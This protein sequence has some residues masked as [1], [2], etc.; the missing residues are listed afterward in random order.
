MANL[1]DSAS[2]VLTPTAYDNGSMLSVKPNDGDGDFDF[3]RNSAATRVNAQGLVE[4]VQILSGDLVSNGDFS[5]EGVQEVSNGSFSQEGA[6]LITNGDFATDTGW[7]KGTGWSISSG[8]ANCNGTTTNLVSNI[9]ITPSIGKLGKL[10]FEITNYVSGQIALSLNGTG[11]SDTGTLTPENGFYE[12]D[13]FG[14]MQANSTFI[15]I[16]STAFIGSI[17]NVSVKEVL[18]D[19]SV[20]DYGAVSPSAV[21]TPNTEGVKLEK[22]VSAD[23]RSSFLVQPISYNS[24]SQY[25][26]TFKLKNG[27]LPSGGSIYVRALY[28]SSSHSI[29]NNLTLTNDWVEY[30]YYYTADSNSLDISFGN[31]D[32]Q[33][34]GVGQ[35]FYINDVSVKEVGQDW[36]FGTG[37]SIGEDKAVSDG[38]NLDAY[39]SQAAIVAGKT[40]KVT[41]DVNDYTSGA[42]SVRPANESSVLSVTA[43]G[44]YVAYVTPISSISIGFRSAGV[45]GFDG[46]VTNISVVEITDDTNLPRINYE[47]FSYQDSLGSEEVP[48]GNFTNQAAVDYWAIAS[49]RATK[50][51]ES[52]FMR[53]TYTSSIGA[54]LFRN[55]LAVS[56]KNYVVTFRAKG[57]ANVTFS[58]IGEN[59]SIGDN[60]TNPII[61]TEWQDYKFNVPLLGITFRF[62]LENGLQVGDTLD[63]ANIS[64]KEYLG[65]EVVPDSGCGSWLLEPQST[66][67]VTYSEDFSDASWSKVN[68]SVVSGFT[69][70]DG[71]S[72]AYSLIEDTSLGQHKVDPQNLS[73]TSGTLYTSSVFAK[74]G[75]RDILQM[76]WSGVFAADR[77]NF[78]LTNGTT[79]GGSAATGKIES[80]GNGWYRCSITQAAGANGLGRCQILLQDSL[81]ASRF[82]S[83]QGNGSGNINIWGAMAEAQSY[84]TSYIPTNGAA[85][86]RL[87]D[88]ANNSGNATLINSTEGVLYVEA[89]AIDPDFANVISLSDGT[90]TNRIAL[91]LPQNASNINAFS[92]VNGVKIDN[93]ILHDSSVNSKY[94][95]VWNG[96]SFKVF[97]NG[98]KKVDNTMSGSFSANALTNVRFDRGDGGLNFHGK[99]KAVVVY[100]EA[101]TDEQLT[102]LTTI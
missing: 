95:I 19:W 47:G 101:L 59:N 46:S 29:V 16:Y 20:K 23:W 98:I 71:L 41:F 65:Q 54:A 36:N 17:D 82:A 58:S 91:T 93:N 38:N 53:L 80:F 12:F 50:S 7:N 5:Q 94:A 45:A 14:V 4:N 97:V 26:V 86:T 37:W 11:G 69:S 90:N 61:T 27:N 60:P 10:R 79:Y 70:P 15:T 39:L 35:Y 56:G 62:Y 67:L 73:L 66:N 83:Y 3:S 89:I 8:T 28:D 68:S 57:T 102:C 24:G 34:A 49:N 25:K 1:L 92:S 76:I 48:D 74:K 78:D 99:T 22:T 85:S 100:K 43:I 52:G 84:S 42:L 64:V 9:P 6:E 33:N 96:N 30:T 2:I 32:W 51:L 72:S 87:Q 18:Q 75:S 44:S 31:V 63:I 77:V 13:L 81:S 55:N 21:I 88:I 40:Y